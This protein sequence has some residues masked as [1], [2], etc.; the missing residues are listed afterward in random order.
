MRPGYRIPVKAPWQENKK[1]SNYILHF[2]VCQQHW[3]RMIRRE[4]KKKCKPRISSSVNLNFTLS[5]MTTLASCSRFYRL[6]LPTCTKFLL[7]L[8]V[9]IPCIC[10][11]ILTRKQICCQHFVL[12]MA[13]Q[14]KKWKKNNKQTCSKLA[15]KKVI[16]QLQKKKTQKEICFVKPEADLAT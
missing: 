7:F 15:N 16:H 13:C 2:S 3:Q 8:K 9:F 1:Y 12:Q 5:A 6:K 11:F 14:K 4:G 10:Y